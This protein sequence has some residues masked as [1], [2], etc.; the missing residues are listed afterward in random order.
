MSDEIFKQHN[1]ERP[2]YVQL[3]IEIEEDCDP[4]KGEYDLFLNKSKTMLNLSAPGGVDDISLIKEAIENHIDFKNLPPE[5][6]VEVILEES[7]EW[8]DVFWHKYYIVKRVT[9]IT[10]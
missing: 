9:E 4:K 7:G 10:T 8:E 3:F 6:T 5:G 1:I 2:N